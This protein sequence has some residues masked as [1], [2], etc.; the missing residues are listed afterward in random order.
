[1]NLP[2]SHSN[3]SLAPRIGSRKQ[4]IAVIIAI[5]ILIV[6]FAVRL[7][8]MHANRQAKTT[9]SATGSLSSKSVSQHSSVAP[10]PSGA[11]GGSSG[12]G[13]TV[14]GATVE[15]PNPEELS[16][17]SQRKTDLEALSGALAK[18][19]K[20]KGAYPT[21]LI[22]LGDGASPFLAT[23]PNDPINVRPNI[24]TYTPSI[25][26]EAFALSACLENGRDSGS[27]VRSPAPPCATK[28]YQLTG[29]E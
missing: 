6:L 16:R 22:D 23:L 18:Y 15:A 5:A 11:A 28:T 21:Q 17:D 13:G 12:S 29:G 14:A 25:N 27:G 10:Q 26:H 9:H 1:M 20:A 8:A 4:F 7:L 19:F 2:K 24:Y 3:E